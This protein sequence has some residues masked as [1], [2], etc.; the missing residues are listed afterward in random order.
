MIIRLNTSDIAERSLVIYNNNTIKMGINATMNGNLSDVV[1][2][3]NP[4]F[5]L[6][7]NET[8]NIDFVTNANTPGVYSGQIIV[9]YTTN[10][11]R[12]VEI[13]SDITVIAYKNPNSHTDPTVLIAIIIIILIIVV[14]VFILKRG[15]R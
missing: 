10:S 14:S 11:S 1:T 6:T 3:K 12:S 4:I 15:K 2:I 9:T 13:P 7:E 8:K 5:E